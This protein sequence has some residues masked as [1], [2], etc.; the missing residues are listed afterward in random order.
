VRVSS[1]SSRVPSPLLICHL[2]KTYKREVGCISDMLLALRK[3]FLFDVFDDAI[4]LMC[5]LG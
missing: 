5:P 2:G 4:G 3:A 1:L